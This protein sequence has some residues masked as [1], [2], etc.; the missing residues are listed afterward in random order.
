MDEG[1]RDRE[2]DCKEERDAAQRDHPRPHPIRQASGDDSRKAA[3]DLQCSED[4][5][6]FCRREPAVVVEEEHDESEQADLSQHVERAPGTE[7]P[8]AWIA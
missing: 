6:S 3:A 1:S 7:E 4:R 8:H 2:R 5:R